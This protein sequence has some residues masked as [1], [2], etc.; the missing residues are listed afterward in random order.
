MVDLDG[1][2]LHSAEDT[3][4]CGR[5][6]GRLLAAWRDA[7]EPGGPATPARFL[8]AYY[9]ARRRLLQDPPIGRITSHAERRAHEWQRRRSDR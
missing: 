2:T 9:R 1:V 6:I 8:G 5:D 4:G 7:G 3:R